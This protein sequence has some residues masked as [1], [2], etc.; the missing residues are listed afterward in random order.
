M[1]NTARLPKVLLVCVHKADRSQMAEAFFNQLAKG[2]PKRFLAG[3]VGLPP[4]PSRL[5]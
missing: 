1:N 5:W 4:L 3:A 2:K